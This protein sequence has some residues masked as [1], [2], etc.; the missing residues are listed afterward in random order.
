MDRPVLLALHVL[1]SA[2]VSV[3]DADGDPATTNLAVLALNRRSSV[4]PASDSH[5][6]ELGPIVTSGATAWVGAR[7]R[8]GTSEDGPGAV[9]AIRDTRFRI[10][11]RLGKPGPSSGVP[12]PVTPGPA[13]VDGSR[14]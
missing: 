4:C 9:V 1:G 3:I 12:P 11:G 8:F 10:R 6:D 2:L 7:P 13:T 5:R 14:V